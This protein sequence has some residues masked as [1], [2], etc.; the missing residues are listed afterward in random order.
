MRSSLISPLSGRPLPQ[1]AVSNGGTVQSGTRANVDTSGGAATIFAPSSLYP[2][3][4]VAAFIV[5]D[6]GGVADDA[7]ITIDGNGRL[8]DGAATY[9]HQNAGAAVLILYDQ[10]GDE[11]RVSLLPSTDP[12]AD[13][14]FFLRRDLL[15]ALPPSGSWSYGLMASPADACVAVPNTFAWDETHGMRFY[16]HVAVTCS[17]VRFATGPAGLGKTFKVTLWDSAGVA[18]A[19]KAGVIGAGNNVAQNALF[20][21]AVTLPAGL[22]TGQRYSVSVK[23]TSAAYVVLANMTM[24]TTPGVGSWPNVNSWP[25][26]MM[27]GVLF[28]QFCWIAGDAYPS[29]DTTAYLSSAEPILAL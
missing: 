12:V 21:A 27:P 1:Q 29:T 25:F 9:T 5:F 11:W 4:E 7:P 14:P 8:I 16:N 15:A 13:Q 23:C 17:G 3:P 28:T 19:T 10:D 24:G 18:L 6:A 20:D 22:A 26:V 2:T